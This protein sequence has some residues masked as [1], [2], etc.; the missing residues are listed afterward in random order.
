MRLSSLFVVTFGTLALA[1]CSTGL[2][3]LPSSQLK[4]PSNQATLV[5]IAFSTNG[6]AVPGQGL[7]LVSDGTDYDIDMNREAS[8]SVEDAGIFVF[9]IEPDRVYALDTIT[10]ENRRFTMSSESFQRLQF[11]PSK[12]SLTHLGTFRLTMMGRT[13]QVEFEPKA[14]VSGAVLSNLQEKFPGRNIDIG[15]NRQKM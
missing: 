14:E 2:K 8:S 11:K 1:A 6:G 7:S 13:G 9:E 5:S 10:F 3:S 4:K 15:L 12:G